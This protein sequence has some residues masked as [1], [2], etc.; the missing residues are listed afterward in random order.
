MTQTILDK[1]KAYKL[2]E[3]AA[4][5]AARPLAEIEAQARDAS[6]VRPFAKALRKASETGY[7]LIAEVKKASPSKGLIRED[8]HPA[9]LAAAY[10]R[11]GATCLSVLTDTPSFQGAK[12]FL[13]EARAATSLPALRKDFMYDTYQVAEAR[14]LGADCILIIM[15]SVSDAQAAELEDAATSWGMDALIEVHNAAELDRALLLKSPLIG[16]NNRNL[17]T[18]ETSLATTRLLSKTVPPER[19]LVSESGLNSPADLADM[20]A[21]GARS[22]LIGESLMRQPDVETATRQLLRDPVAA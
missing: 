15:A 14:A 5:K 3:V 19:L 20:A 10:E 6:P 11:G 1:I 12:Q 16:I 17:N 21:Y 2:E 9:T 22:F 18:F 13:V 4:D 8:F 7:G